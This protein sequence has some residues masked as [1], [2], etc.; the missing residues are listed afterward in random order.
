[1]RWSARVPGFA[2]E[3]GLTQVA[4]S[5]AH[6]ASSVGR[7]VTRFRGDDAEALRRA[8]AGDATAWEGTSYAWPEQLDMFG[9]QTAKNVRAVRDTLRHRVLREGN[10]RD[11]GYPR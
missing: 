10:G 8:I 6:R 5:D 11:L 7:A 3:I 4:G 2:F 1:M 9:H